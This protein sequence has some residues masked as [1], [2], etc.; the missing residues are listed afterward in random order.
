M[1]QGPKKWH[2]GPTPWKVK[3]KRLS[4]QKKRMVGLKDLKPK[5]HKGVG[6]KSP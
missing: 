3:L 1:T 5:I 4:S 2:I 6:F